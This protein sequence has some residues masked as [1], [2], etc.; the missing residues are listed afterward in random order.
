MCAQ[1]HSYGGRPDVVL[2]NPID[3]QKANIELQNY[4]R[5][6][7]FEIGRAAF[8]ALVIA[9]PGGNKLRLMSDPNQDVGTVRVLT[10][11]AWKLWHL[12]DLVHTIMDD[13][14]EL[15]KDPGADAFQLGIRSWPNLVCFDP[16]ANGVITGF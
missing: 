1:I 5:Y 4:A 8:G 15:R 12:N 7:E 11:D 2:L 10:M 13:G 9:S 16:R 6:E 3:W 14:L